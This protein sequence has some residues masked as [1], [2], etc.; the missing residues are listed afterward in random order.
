MKNRKIIDK[1]MA[2]LLVCALAISSAR[3]GEYVQANAKSIT[4]NSIV[5]AQAEENSKLAEIKCNK[6]SGIYIGSVVV[7]LSQENP[8]AKIYYT[9]DGTTPSTKSTLYN[10]AFTISENCTVKAIAIAEGYLN[11]NVF[12]TQYTIIKSFNMTKE[13]ITIDE[14][15]TEQLDYKVEPSDTPL[16]DVT[17]TSSDP[18]VATVDN[19]GKVEGKRAGGAVITA[20]LKNGEFVQCMVFVKGV[21]FK[22]A[23]SYKMNIG[24]E[25]NIYLDSSKV[26]NIAWKS[27]DKKVANVDQNG[28]VEAHKAGSCTISATFGSTVKTCKITVAPATLKL[29]KT[30]IKLPFGKSTK[31]AYETNTKYRYPALKNSNHKAVIINYD[32]SITAIGEG[33]SKITLF[34]EGKKATCTVTVPKFKVDSPKKITLASGQKRNVNHIAKV[35]KAFADATNVKIANKKIV[36]LRDETIIGLHYGETTLTAKV[37]GK[38]IKCKIVVPKTTIKTVKETSVKYNNSKTIKIKVTTKNA[39]V[40]IKS[41]KSSNKAGVEVNVVG[42]DCIKLTAKKYNQTAKITLVLTDGSKQELKV[43]VPKKS[44]IERIKEQKIICTNGEVYISGNMVYS[45]VYISNI[46][47]KTITNVDYTVF[48]YDAKG[49][50]ISGES[51]YKYNDSKLYSGYRVNADTF[52]GKF[53]CWSDTRMMRCCVEKVWFDDGT[54]WTNPLYKEWVKEYNKKYY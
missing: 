25:R 27:S 41:A 54:T 35:N 32:G 47:G 45:S 42:E 18:S 39:K 3:T 36:D 34:L 17:W 9:V 1:T 6:E 37:G 44:V 14:F 12:T 46:Y 21:D 5:K 13:T 26:Y 29:I 23:S 30:K 50:R 22:I 7:E 19:K 16:G 24:E 4:K 31:I 48:E 28:Y 51:D 43:V 10:G 15:S 40:E 11:S 20:T 8:N 49:N 38:T 2:G 52:E 33:T 53:Y